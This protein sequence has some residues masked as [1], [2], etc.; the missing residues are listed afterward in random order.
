VNQAGY[1]YGIEGVRHGPVSLEEIR[2]LVRE[3]RLRP[4]D[5]IWNARDEVWT[6]VMEFP[7]AM[8]AS[9]PEDTRF[10]DP[11]AFAV[12]ATDF[13][14]VEAH[15]PVEYAG[16]WIRVGAF[17][18][19]AFVLGFLGMIWFLI[20]MALGWMSHYLAVVEN[21]DH[22]SLQELWSALPWAYYAGSTV[23]T[24]LYE[25]LFISSSWQATLGKRA[26][27]IRVTDLNG[28]RCG[29]VRASVRFV[30]K[31][32]ISCLFFIGFLMVAFTERKQGLHDLVAGTYCEKL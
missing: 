25:S 13:A 32:F 16:F 10:G 26:M 12:H 17:I 19:D 7:G 8:D 30:V 28:G 11:S 5:Y 27:G 14:P 2:R 24:W 1:W 21:S 3:G 31:N 4:T 29:F 22:L 9:E 6:R 20:A 23:I 15:E 18:I